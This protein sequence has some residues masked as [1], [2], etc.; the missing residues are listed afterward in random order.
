[1]TKPIIRIHNTE[2][3]EIV[4]REMN[5]KEFAAYE[6]DQANYQAKLAEDQAK[7]AA[8]ATAESKLAALGLTTNDLRALGL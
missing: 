2:T 5:D 8:K 4:D 1:M 7:I 6:I 3:D